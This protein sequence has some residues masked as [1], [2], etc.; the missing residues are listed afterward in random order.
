VVIQKEQVFLFEKQIELALNLNLPVL[1][2][3]RKAFDEVFSILK[4]F[5]N[6]SKS[7]LTGVF[8]C[9]SGSKTDIKK[10]EEI[11]FYFGLDGNLTYNVGLQNVVKL[12]PLEKTLIETDCPFLA[13]EP[14]RGLRNEPKNVKIVAEFIGELKQ[15]SFSKV[16]QTTTQNAKNLFKIN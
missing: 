1:V 14:F 13:P 11:G 16:A 4:R 7:N 6:F 9:Y 10:V 5:F 8:H 2:H 15:I 12:I 3:S